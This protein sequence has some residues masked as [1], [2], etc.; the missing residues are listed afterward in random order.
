MDV[1]EMFGQFGCI[2]CD[3]AQH[4]LYLLSCRE[5]RG[6]LLL[7]LQAQH[8][9]AGA[10]AGMGAGG[11]AGWVQQNGAGRLPVEA[12]L[13]QPA[14]QG[15]P[16]D[17]CMWRLCFFSPSMVTVPLCFVVFF[18]FFPFFKGERHV[19]CRP[20]CTWVGHAPSHR[21]Q[22]QVQEPRQISYP[23]LLLQGN[24]C[25]SIPFSLFCLV[26]VKRLV[27]A[28][29][30]HSFIHPFIHLLHFFIIAIVSFSVGCEFLNFY[31][32]TKAQ[33]QNIMCAIST[34]T[35]AFLLIF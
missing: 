19:P 29:E 14:L 34:N 30:I 32:N 21:G 10:A 35:D 28:D 12:V 6:A 11:P 4:R 25:T 1:W 3:F 31:K 13:C 20:V 8:G 5:L 9:W 22:L 16:A 33:D 26:L 15:Q 2:L 17:V 27:V 23:V 7:L 18:F 24:S